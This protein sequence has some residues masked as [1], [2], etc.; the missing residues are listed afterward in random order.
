MSEVRL[1]IERIDL[2]DITRPTE[3]LLDV[4]ETDET[5]L[6]R[7]VAWV[8]VRGYTRL[9]PSL[10]RLLG[11]PS[12]EG[13]AALINRPEAL[14]ILATWPWCRGPHDLPTLYGMREMP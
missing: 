13:W 4:T 11:Q 9:V 6:D 7:A 8:T 10:Q 14:A 3:V 2:D 1:T 5:G 12:K